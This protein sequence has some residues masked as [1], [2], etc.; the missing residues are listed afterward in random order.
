IVYIEGFTDST[1]TFE[2]NKDLSLKRAE[3]ARDYL[4]KEHGISSGR[5][6]TIGHGPDF[7]VADNRT[8]AGRALNRRVEMIV[9]PD[10]I[11]KKSSDPLI[12]NDSLKEK[13]ESKLV[14]AKRSKLRKTKP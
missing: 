7:P 6:H 13:I 8:A 14:P 10:F 9:S 4:M 11:Q 3:A 5:I 12:L 1:G 2:R